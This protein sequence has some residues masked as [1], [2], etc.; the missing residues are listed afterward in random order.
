MVNMEY[1]IDEQSFKNMP[2][3][4]QNYMLYRTFNSHRSACDDRICAIER[5]LEGIKSLKTRLLYLASGFGIAG[6]AGATI[7]FRE[8]LDRF[9][10]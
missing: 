8:I 2:V 7:S 5:Q 3:S 4:D 9:F 10:K 6:G 1:E